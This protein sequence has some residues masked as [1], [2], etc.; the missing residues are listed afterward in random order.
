MR[1]RKEVDRL[2]LDPD[3]LPS[4]VVV[5]DNDGLIFS[6][7]ISGEGRL[8]KTGTGTTE[9]TGLASYSG[10][11][12]VLDGTLRGNLGNLQGQIDLFNGASLVIAQATNGTFGGT[13][14]S[15]SPSS[16]DKL[17]S[18]V[19]TFL[20]T[21]PFS[22]DLNVAGGGVYFSAGA[23]LP[24]AGLTIGMGGT[25]S[26]VSLGADFDPKD[27]LML[28][29]LEDAPADRVSLEEA[30]TDLA[31]EDTRLKRIQAEKLEGKLAD[32]D[33]IMEAE[34]ELLEGIAAIIK[35]SPMDDAR[36]ADVFASIRDHGKKWGAKFGK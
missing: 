33:E 32:I 18:G 35:S 31:I 29:P 1:T 9:L 16:V 28:R 21:Q 34:S 6:G 20:N 24:N 25:G 10:G 2:V 30:R 19:V 23:S 4:T 3:H 13:I 22:G 12:E 36:K 8:I 7:D 5:F 27:V 17:G 26:P 14:D 15:P 11:T